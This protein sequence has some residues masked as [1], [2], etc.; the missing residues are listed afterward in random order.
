MMTKLEQAIIDTAR[1]ELLRMQR[2]LTNPEDVEEATS[3]FHTLMAYAML[4]HLSNSG[5]SEA[6]I[7]ELLAFEKEA[8][9]SISRF[10][11]S[12]KEPYIPTQSVTIDSSTVNESSELQ[13]VKKA[14]SQ[15]LGGSPNSYKEA[16]L[17][18]IDA[19]DDFRRTMR[20]FHLS[21][22][23][24]A[25]FQW[26]VHDGKWNFDQYD[27]DEIL[28]VGLVMREESLLHERGYSV[29][30][31]YAAIKR[32]ESLS[33]IRKEAFWEIE[34][35]KQS[36]V[37]C[38]IDDY[39]PAKAKRKIPSIE[40]RIRRIEKELSLHG[41]SFEEDQLVEWREKLVF[42]KQVVTNC[43]KT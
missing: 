25:C 11:R 9:Q 22:Y 7:A 40:R 42:F 20:H 8:A 14:L 18:A 19:L 6:A 16:A 33:I 28:T 2:P 3:A 4:A 1:N 12:V 36:A 37:P 26:H 17:E 32:P 15:T 41:V 38:E 31:A 10:S 35:F 24:N 34:Q 21:R 23:V 39:D 5:L 27:D 29:P 43:T 13:E 30:Q